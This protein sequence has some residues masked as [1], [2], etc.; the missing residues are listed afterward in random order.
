[1]KT[2][3]FSWDDG[4]PYDLQIAEKFANFGFTADFY[5]CKY[6]IEGRRTMPP[7]EVRLLSDLGMNIGGHTYNHRY[8]NS[9][10]MNIGEQEVIDGQD[11]VAQTL[12]QASTIFSFPGGKI[13][14]YS[15]EQAFQSS[16][17]K[18]ARTTRNFSNGRFKRFS[19][20][21]TLQ[22]FRHKKRVHIKNFISSLM[23]TPVSTSFFLQTIRAR[24]SIEAIEKIINSKTGQ[25]TYLHFWGHSWEVQNHALLKDLEQVLQCL[26][27]NSFD[28]RGIGHYAN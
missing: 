23:S 1:M 17:I 18:L 13:P 16:G 21:T 20:P 12:G 22:F 2:A 26:A 19:V 14:K 15:L 9:C 24:D 11:Y 25:G 6:N 4:F 10:S 27:D 7:N 8:L 28:V 5:V 3:I